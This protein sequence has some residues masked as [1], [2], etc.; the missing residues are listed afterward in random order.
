MDRG[1][2]A[3]TRLAYGYLCPQYGV[4][5]VDSHTRRSM[6]S[7][8]EARPEACSTGRREFESRPSSQ[9]CTKNVLK[10][11]IKIFEIMCDGSDF[12]ADPIE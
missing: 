3:S 4:S 5:A 7:D 6:I 12:E 9:Y 11:P 10:S 8:E 2:M 1:I